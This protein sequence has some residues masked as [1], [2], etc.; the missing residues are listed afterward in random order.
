MEMDDLKALETILKTLAA[1]EPEE[2]GRVLRW[3]AEKLNLAPLKEAKRVAHAGVEENGGLSEF[4][5]V[6]EALAATHANSDVDR[7]LVAA[8]FLTKKNNQAE[9]TGQE[10]NRHL[11]DA[12]HGIGN[13]TK[14]I[15]NLKNR[16]PQLM[17]QT[18]KGGSSKQAR[19]NYKVTAAG[20]AAVET[21]LNSVQGDS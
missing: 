6:P 12:G 18:K 2:Q 3:A 9:L 11:K 1:L 14:A 16:K 19:K 10:I 13:I 7:A 8:A 21:L 17:V 5:S 15:T 4:G 20:F